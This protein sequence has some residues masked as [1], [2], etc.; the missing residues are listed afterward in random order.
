M[1]NNVMEFSNLTRTAAEAAEQIGCSVAQI[2]KSIIFKTENDEAVLVIASG[3][4]RVDE[5]LVEN[6]LGKKLLKADADFVREKTGFVI[7][8]VP[9]YGH[10][11]KIITY[12][13]E[14]LNEYPEIWA[15]AGKTNAVFK[16]SLEE[17][18]EKT[19]GKIIKVKLTKA[20]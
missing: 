11:N 16:T 10:K 14:D 5:K 3:I 2:A 9:P 13:D 15:S 7:G 17:L 6:D 19:E 1:Y 12:I 4:N 20:E 8:G 18:V